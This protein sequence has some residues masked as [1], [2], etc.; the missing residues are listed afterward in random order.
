MATRLQLSL[1]RWPRAA[2]SALV[3]LAV[4]P[5]PVSMQVPAAR[6]VAIGDIHGAYDEL[7]TILRSAKLVDAQLRWSGGPAVLVQTG[8]YTDRG[9]DVRKVM[10]L[11]MQL[12]TEARAA[13]GQA[14][15]L[16]GNHEIMN[17]IG[18]LRDVTPEICVSFTTDNSARLREETWTK[19][20]RIARTRG[21]MLT[22]TP[23]VYSQTRET[24]MEAHPLGCL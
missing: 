11:L 9:R 21:R 22:P 2:L 8:D 13:G 3:V 6:V 10:D 18:D 23:A 4:W 1:H 5:A 15:V 12:E 24:W 20:E 14:R 16:A 7:T 19:Y 17:V